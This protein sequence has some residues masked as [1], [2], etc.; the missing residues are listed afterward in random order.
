MTD[1]KALEREYNKYYAD[2]PDIW[3]DYGRDEFALLT[4]IDHI[5]SEPE[6]LLDVGCGNGHTIELF[7]RHWKNTE[8]AGI[9]LSIKAIELA[10]KRVPEAMFINCFLDDI[11]Y[12]QKFDVV[13]CLGV[14]EHFEDLQEGL[15]ALRKTVKKDGIV[16]LEVPNCIGYPSSAEVEGFRRVN[17][18]SGQTEWHLYRHTWERE[19][20]KAGFE[21]V[22]AIKGINIYSEFVWLLKDGTA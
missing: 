21:I 15:Q 22:K 4:L 2:N 12:T 5:K 18:G 16:Y 6:T 17:F 7:S 1:R 3:I 10:S 14:A 11:L 8:Y 13:L 9:D 19:L 20:N